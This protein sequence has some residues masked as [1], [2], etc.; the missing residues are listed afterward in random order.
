MND[1]III[2]GASG[3][4]KVVAD[5]AKLNGYKEIIFLDDD[6]SKR[7]CGSYLVVGTT[8]E[9]KLYIKE[10][11]LIVAIGNNFIREKITRI[12]DQYGIKQRTLIHPSAVI[13]DTVTIEEGTVVMANVVI[14][15][16]TIKGKNCIINTASTVDHDCRVDDFVHISP[17]V[18]IAGTVRVGTRT[19]IGIGGIIANNVNICN[20]CIIGAGAVVIKNI[21]QS[22]T[23]VG[24]PIRKVK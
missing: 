7:Q 21:K 24:V 11:D 3:H 4:G 2:I 17:G 23:Y 9:I 12:L 18:N 16:N 19:W 5:I 14:N 6:I 22:G 1:K 8:K 10:Y 20:E 15:A 13:D